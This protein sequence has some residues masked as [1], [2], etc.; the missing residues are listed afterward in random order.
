MHNNNDEP[1]PS[2]NRLFFIF[3]YLGE[4]GGEEVE[5]CKVTGNEEFVF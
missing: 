3:D 5:E 4:A 2:L 1:I